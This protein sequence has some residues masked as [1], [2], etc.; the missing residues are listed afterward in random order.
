[1]KVINNQRNPMLPL[2]EYLPDPEARVMPDGQ[3]YV[4]ADFDDR[5]DVF[6]SETMHF[7]STPDMQH[8]R[9]YADMLNGHDVPWFDDPS[10]P[11][12]PGIDWSK[13]TP[14]VQKM[15][16]GQDGAAMK[17]KFEAQANLPKPPLLFAPDAI[18]K[19]GRY[20]LFFNMSDDTEGVAV[21]DTPTGPFEIKAQLPIG[22]IDPSVFIDTD[23]QAYLYWGQ[24][25]SHGVKLND[26]LLGLNR[27][28]IVD[29]LVTEEQ[30]YFHEGSSM[31]KI[32][33]TYYYVYA[34]MQRGKPTAL[35]YATGKSPL[36]PFTYRGIIIDNA[37]CDPQSWNNHGSIECFNG[38]WYV[39][40]HR[41]SR[42][43][44]L[45]RRLCI[46]PITIQADGTIPEVP[47]TSQGVGE[48]F[49]PDEP[50]MGYQ[51]CDVA[52]GAFI[53]QD[54]AYGE[55]LTNLVA[56]SSAT[57]RYVKS[58]EAWQDISLIA[59]GS[60]ELTV[61]L[62]DEVCGSVTIKDGQVMAHQLQ[63]P[64]GQYTLTLQVVAGDDLQIKQ[65]TLH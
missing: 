17:K 20:Y 28:D 22:G 4:Y 16:A 15:L 51:A 47:M 48:P 40:Y 55:T 45:H 42:N 13:P 33:D 24:L 30:H 23:G 44:K 60:G 6:C 65:V 57:F 11:H 21:A 41:S 31:R 58:T 29:D 62:D 35:G 25:Y 61:K 36:G 43:S 46:E 27:D 5:D 39:F 59:T 56:G 52:G 32:G 19:D 2:D 18:E 12:Y 1:M 8:W 7:A 34:D 14:F 64:A 53:D 54:Q 3:L 49:A 9:V 63:A 37:N 38:Q 26:D 50:I 10:Y